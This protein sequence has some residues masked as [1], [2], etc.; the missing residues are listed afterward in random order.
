MYFKVGHMLKLG[1]SMRMFILQ[2]PDD[3]MEEESDLTV[4]QLKEKR[5]LEIE[6]RELKEMQRKEEE[7]ENRK[8]LEEKEAN[9]GIDWGMG[10]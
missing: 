2:G 1:S 8:R 6:E 7:E 9:E 5:K 3:D 10:V 4:T